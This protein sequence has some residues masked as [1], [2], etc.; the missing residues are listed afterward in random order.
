MKLK[1]TARAQARPSL[2]REIKTAGK[3]ERII[4]AP[5]RDRL[6]ADGSDLSFVTVRVVDGAGT[7][8]PRADN[9][10]NFEIQGEGKIVG[11][12]NGYQ[13]SH[14]PFQAKYRKA[15]NGMCL[16]VLQSNGKAGSISLTATS[17]G[18]QSAS[19]RVLAK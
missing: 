11:V 17:E 12:D 7:L 18:L 9:L 19:V 10:I 3:P 6:K 1:A 2:T 4:L 5:D 13:A 8:A 14:E 15:F 16:V